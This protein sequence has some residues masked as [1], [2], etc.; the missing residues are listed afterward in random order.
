MIILP[1][2]CYMLR[3]IATIFFTRFR[4]TWTNIIAYRKSFFVLTFITKLSF[5]LTVSSKIHLTISSS[6]THFI[7]AIFLQAQL[8]EY[9]AQSPVHIKTR[10]LP[11]NRKSTT[12]AICC[13]KSVLHGETRWTYS[14]SGAGAVK[15]SAVPK[16]TESRNFNCTC[17]RNFQNTLDLTAHL[18]TVQLKLKVKLY[19][20]GVP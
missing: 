15:S 16:D 1:A 18:L 6:L 19:A 12:C 14:G 5:N 3:I 7:P 10:G 20:W 8:R 13:L 9:N 17:V 11:R 4:F 2:P